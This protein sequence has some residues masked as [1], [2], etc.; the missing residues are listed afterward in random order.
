MG[1]AG[2]VKLVE[3]P[4]QI[5]LWNTDSSVPDLDLHFA[6]PPPGAQENPAVLAVPH[7]VGDQV[8]HDR[9][10]DRR[11]RTGPESRFHP[12]QSNALCFGLPLQ[13]LADLL[14]DRV[15]RA[16]SPSNRDDARIQPCDLHQHVQQLAHA[17]QNRMHPVGDV[18][19][20]MGR[21]P[22]VP[23][24][25][26]E[27]GDEQTHC[28][29]GLPQVVAGRGQK[30][31]FSPVGRFRVFLGPGEALDKR[32]VLHAQLDRFAKRPR[33]AARE[34]RGEHQVHQRKNAKH[35]Q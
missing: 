11:I 4:G 7:R 3:H 17:V 20:R 22:R 2:L 34:R 10:Q 32:F 16:R 27:C 18:G 31:C 28:M 6:A 33:D 23:D 15:H 12:L 26:L 9:V 5:L 29:D 13:D 19:Q 1:I 21:W 25:A 8:E 14:Q 30:P 35:V 24:Q